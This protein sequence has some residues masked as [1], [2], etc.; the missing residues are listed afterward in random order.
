[1]VTVV[2][3]Q[4]SIDDSDSNYRDHHHGINYR[5]HYYGTD[6]IGLVSGIDM[7]MFSQMR[8]S[9][10]D[11]VI[12]V[13]LPQSLCRAIFTPSRKY[14]RIMFDLI[15]LEDN[16]D[17]E[18][19]DECSF[20]FL[21][22]YEGWDPDI[23]TGVLIEQS[24]CMLYR[25]RVQLAKRLALKAIKLASKTAWPGMF[26]A[27]A[28]L[29]ISACYRRKNKLGKAKS[30]LEKAEQNLTNTCYYEAWCE[31]YNEYGS[32]L[33]AFIDAVSNPSSQL[34]TDAKDC[35]H[36]QLQAANRESRRKVKE[37]NEF[38]AL[39]KIARTLLDANTL[40]GQQRQVPAADVQKARL[41]LELIEKDLCME[42]NMPLGTHIQF[43]LI[44][45]KLYF[46][47]RKYHDGLRVLKNCLEMAQTR[48]YERDRVLIA[49]GVKTLETLTKIEEKPVSIT[50][51]AESERKNVVSNETS[52][53]SEKESEVSDSIEIFQSELGDS[54]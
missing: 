35:F 43:L 23:T 9:S 21:A 14:E 36:K 12:R 22:A 32:Y 41:Y 45:T 50:Q 47:E 24:R 31:Y 33:N 34:L 44:K 53:C 49:E 10:I 2:S 7:N 29:V 8:S 25:D 42:T 13:I 37:K 48:G 17:F 11:H 54:C 26:I 40:F 46:R 18:A 38:Y 6:D 39:L 30:F 19:F 51:T 4:M 28:C 3:R 5:D 27:R 16:G 20:A 15:R 1:M 52:C